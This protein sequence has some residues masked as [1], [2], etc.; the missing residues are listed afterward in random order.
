VNAGAPGPAADAFRQALRDLG[1]VEGKDVVI[2]AR[3]AEGHQARLPEFV[4]EMIRLKVDVLVVGSTLTAVAAK[5]ATTTIPIV[6][7]SLFDPVGAGIVASLA[8]PG[9]NITG[10]AV[11]VAAGFGGK[12]VQLLKEAVP[13]ISH[14]AV[15]WNSANPASG[16]AVREIQASAQTLNVKLDTFDTGNA[17][18][19]DRALAA[20]G[21]S[22][23]QG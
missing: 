13:G 19:L 1:Y 5:K 10:A 23:T 12:W 21:T 20:I 9:G 11:G 18:A 4:A 7:A 14:A 3:F 2:E 8:R 16:Q 17:T 6:F 15:L 22:G